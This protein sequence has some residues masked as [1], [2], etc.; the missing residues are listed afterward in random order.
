TNPGQ[1]FG[2]AEALYAYK[3]MKVSVA[4]GTAVISVNKYRNAD[5]ALDKGG[6]QHA[7]VIKDK[8][9]ALSKDVWARAGGSV[10]YVETFMGKGSP[11]SIAGVLEGLAAHSDA[12]IKAYAKDKGTPQAK[13]ASIL[14]DDSLDWGQTLQKICDEYIGLDCNGFVGN[15]LKVV[16]PHFKLH[17]N[18]RADEV[19][20]KVVTYRT[21][22]DQI[23]YWD[24][25]CYA[26]NEHIAA[27]NGPGPTAGTFMVC[28]SAGG[29]PRMNEHRFVKTGTNLFRL[30]A[31]TPQDIGRD[32][33]VISL[34]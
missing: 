20:K 16:E 24:V 11:W 12:F 15:W 6:C 29:G 1:F 34:W 22:L 2:P 8:L 23:E 9:R 25:M 17:Q 13:C 19:R 7:L 28:Q 26:K 14:A 3:N 21:Q 10:A 4:G 5:H 30:A 27:V 32:F 18:H 33:Y 31:P